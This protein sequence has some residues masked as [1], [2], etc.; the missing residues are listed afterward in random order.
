MRSPILLWTFLSTGVDLCGF[1]PELTF[2][3]GDVGRISTP[4]LPSPSKGGIFSICAAAA[5]LLSLIVPVVM[6]LDKSS[7]ETLHRS[8]CNNSPT[9]VVLMPWKCEIRFPL[10]H[11]SGDR[12]DVHAPIITGLIWHVVPSSCAPCIRSACATAS[13]LC[14]WRT[15]V[16]RFFS[17]G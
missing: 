7:W 3:G 17:F 10:I 15:I 4:A 14:Y 13:P 11:W 1:P 9:L 16:P 8:D 12:R 2:S 5:S 6:N